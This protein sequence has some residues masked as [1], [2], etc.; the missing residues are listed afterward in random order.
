MQLPVHHCS[1]H[2]S[3]RQEGSSLTAASSRSKLLL[4]QL[5]LDQADQDPSTVHQSATSHASLTHDPHA[6]KHQQASIMTAPGGHRPSVQIIGPHQCMPM[7]DPH[8][9]SCT[10]WEHTHSVQLHTHYEAA[11]PLYNPSRGS[12][13]SF[14]Q[15]TFTPWKTQY[16]RKLLQ[17]GL[18]RPSLQLCA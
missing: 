14:V 13:Y 2:P 18:S 1:S 12:H 17:H 10:Y 7:Q 15:S 8:D 5:Q 9:S 6:S 11:R 4:V 3:W 16:W